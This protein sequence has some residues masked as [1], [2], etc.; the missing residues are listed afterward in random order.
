MFPH[1]TPTS[2]PS[3]PTSDRALYKHHRAGPPHL[4]ATLLVVGGLW[5]VVGEFDA[6][7]LDVVAAHIVLQDALHQQLRGVV[8]ARVVLG[9]GLEPAHEAVVLAEL[10]HLFSD[11]RELVLGEVHFVGQQHDG[12]GLVAL[13]QLHLA[14]NVVLPLLYCLEC[15]QP[16][17]D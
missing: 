6:L 4:A 13:G 2:A 3:V 8:D 14:V 5:L 1:K 17:R 15:G 10:V 9:R 11:L 7:A 12:N 16:A